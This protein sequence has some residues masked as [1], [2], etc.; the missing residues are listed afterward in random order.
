MYDIIIIGGGPAGLTAAIYTKRAGF[1]TLL[2]EGG[3]LGGQAATT[4]E[5]E[6]WPG[7]Q[8]ITGPDFS[9][10]LY[11]QSAALGAEIKFEAATS[12]EDLGAVKAVAASSGERYEGRAV[13]LANGVRRRRLDVPGEADLA[14]R[15]VS[16]C[17]TCDGNFFKGRD[18]AVVGGGNTALEDAF[19]LATLCPSVWLVCR[20]GQFRGDRQLID[21]VAD[22]KNIHL[23][24]DT[25]VLAVEGSVK[26][27]GLRVAGPKGERTLP[28]SGVF[29]AV[30]LAPDNLPFSPPLA[31]DEDGYVQAGEDCSTNVPG[32]FVAGDTRS[33][34]L[35]QLVTAAADGA[36]AADAAGKYLH[37]A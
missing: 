4:P 11:Q 5:I 36:A 33:K 15:G 22:V 21:S 35:R 7:T 8:R 6:N 32:I 13:I 27:T 9:S 34:R 26:V 31:L 30:G 29:A 28:V 16:Y 10:S 12:L 1:S 14:G 25:R 18:V 3:A 20:R 17:A 37:Q 19:F 24:M 23:L 2:L